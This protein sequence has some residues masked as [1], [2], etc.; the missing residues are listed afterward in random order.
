MQKYISIIFFLLVFGVVQSQNTVTP[1]TK[2]TAIDSIRDMNV[3]ESDSI[4]KSNIKKSKLYGIY[5]P[6]DI[7]DAFLELDR[8]SPKE[9]IEKIKV[10]DEITMAKKLHFGLGKWISHNWNLIEG[11]RYSHYLRG[12]GLTNADDMIDFTLIS[13]HRYLNKR[14]Q[15]IE[16]RVKEY[17]KKNELKKDKKN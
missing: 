3:L 17:R 12:L 9:S 4:Y 8:L 14:P 16:I 11:S 15:E 1:K 5:I 6:K 13:Y 7:D 2:K 10:I